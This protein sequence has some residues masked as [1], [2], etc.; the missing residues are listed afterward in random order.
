MPDTTPAENNHLSDLR[1]PDANL[2]TD[3][4]EGVLD[5]TPEGQGHLRPNFTPGDN[6]IYISSS[7]IYRFRLR[8]GD[9]VGGQVR[10]PKENE[11]YF[12]LLRVE[13]VNGQPADE[14]KERPVFEELL[15][16]FPDRWVKMETKQE[17]LS[18]RV[19]DLIAP[20]GNGQRGMIVSPPK[21]GKTWLMK[22]IIEGVAKNYPD[23]HLMVV[24]VG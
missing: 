5:I 12:G 19:I 23:V 20:I 14:I 15:P 16:V 13:T 4:K 24:L 1:I 18:T 21:A 8:P 6:D 9:M 10:A 2:P 17:I 22:D 11:R 3:F 7:Q